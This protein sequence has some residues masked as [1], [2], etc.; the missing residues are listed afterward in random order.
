MGQASP[1]SDLYAL[2]AT[3]LHL[4]TGRAPPDF[5]TD[6]GRLEVPATLSCGE[7]LRGVLARLLAAAPAHR[8]QSAREARAALL[9]G[10]Q[11]ASA[12][13][14]VTP[15]TALTPLSPAR[16][17]ALGPVPR[18]LDA[19][20]KKLLRAVGHSMWDLMATTEK[21]GTRWA[22]ADWFLVGFFSLLTAGILPAT[23]W[24]LSRSRRRRLTPFVTHGLPAVARVLEMTN[25][26]V[27]FDVSLTRVRYEFEAGGRVHRNADLVLPWVSERWDV[28]T[29]IQ[30]LY[31]PDDEYDSVIVSTA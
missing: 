28:G 23:F 29:A 22:V 9:T 20:A 12:P 1:A 30:V 4:V 15:S 19:D 26:P 21:P 14:G 3:F 25:E 2:G 6:A 24:S 8:F 17:V 18:P 31:L 27:G 16:A 13:Q 7:P 11:L 5:M 10:S